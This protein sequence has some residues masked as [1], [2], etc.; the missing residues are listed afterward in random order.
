LRDVTVDHM[1]EVSPGS[2]RALDRR[3]QG[4]AAL[5]DFLTNEIDLAFTYLDTAKLA[6]EPEHACSLLDQVRHAIR[7]TRHFCGRLQDRDQWQAIHDRL[8]RL[9]EAADSFSV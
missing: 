6:T 5:V 8:D 9:E 2:E 1:A 3:E 7:S 4:Q